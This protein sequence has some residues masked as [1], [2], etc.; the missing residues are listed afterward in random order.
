MKASYRSSVK[1]ETWIKTALFVKMSR[2]PRAHAH[3]WL[4]SLLNR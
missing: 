4:K 2:W 1:T 3:H